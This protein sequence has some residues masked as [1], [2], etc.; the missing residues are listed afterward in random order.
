MSIS[1]TDFNSYA[2]EVETLFRE[3]HEWSKQGVSESLG[4]QV[5]PLEEIDH[6]YDI[7]AIIAEDIATLTDPDADSRLFIARTDSGI[8]GCVFLRR[9]SETTAEV[10]RL[11]VRPEARDNGLGRS[12]MEALIEAAREDGYSTLLLFTGPFTEAAQSLY[13]DLGFEY[14]TPF[15]CEAPEEAYGEL[16]FMRLELGEQSV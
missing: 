5:I 13:E 6:A 15:E 10:K 16:I 2:D 3:Y 1:E 14:T 9:R 8:V 4:G 11:Y 12:L 7:D